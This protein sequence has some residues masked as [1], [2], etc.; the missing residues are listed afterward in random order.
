MPCS[1]STRSGT[2]ALH[3]VEDE[4]ERSINVIVHVMNEMDGVTSQ[5]FVH[6]LALQM[7]I[8]RELLRESIPGAYCSRTSQPLLVNCTPTTSSV[9]DAPLT[10][11]RMSKNARSTSGLS[12]HGAGFSIL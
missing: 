1:L 8:I 12:A 2:S 7:F 6:W 11:V 3:D 5:R 10:V 9:F 4:R